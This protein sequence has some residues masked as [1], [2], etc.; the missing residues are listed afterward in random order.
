MST[1]QLKLSDLNLSRQQIF[2]LFKIS[3]SIYQL[4]LHDLIGRGANVQNY[5]ETISYV[6][7]SL[8]QQG[9]L[10]KRVKE[11][12]ENISFID[13]GLKEALSANKYLLQSVREFFEPYKPINFEEQFISRPFDIVQSIKDIRHYPDILV[14]KKSL[15]SLEI[16]FP[17]NILFGI[18]SEL[19]EN[20]ARPA[21]SDRRVIINWKVRGSKFQCEVHDNGFGLCRIDGSKFLPLDALNIKVKSRRSTKRGLEIIN[22]IIR[23]SKGLLLFSNSKTLGGTLVYF[24]FPVFGMYK[25]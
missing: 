4:A 5:L 11:L 20:A 17:E 23:L 15:R 6:F 3:A 25:R 8:K 9:A 19:V 10:T 14:G 7:S 18:L 21:R 12:D 24:E 2:D 1:K 13:E 22:R 16:V